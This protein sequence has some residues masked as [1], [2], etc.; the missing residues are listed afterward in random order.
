MFKDDLWYVVCLCSMD[1]QLEFYDT[2]SLDFTLMASAEHSMATDLEWDPTGRYV[3]TSVSYWSQKV[4]T[5]L[6]NYH[7]L[8][9]IWQNISLIITF[10]VKYF[11][12]YIASSKYFFTLNIQYI[13]R[14]NPHSLMLLQWSDPTT[15]KLL[16]HTATTLYGYCVLYII[17]LILPFVQGNV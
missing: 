16:I 10:K 17:S 1:G 3:V 7:S 8:E 13:T 11:H 5:Y 14:D 12:G 4:C 6:C 9:V 15:V 2:D